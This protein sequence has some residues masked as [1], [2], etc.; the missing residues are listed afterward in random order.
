MEN[1]SQSEG[2]QKLGLELSATNITEGSWA[3]AVW[4]KGTPQRRIAFSARTRLDHGKL[5]PY[6]AF[7]SVC[8]T[9]AGM[10]ME[11]GEDAYQ[12]WLRC[13]EFPDTNSYRERFQ[14]LLKQRDAL[15]STLGHAAVYDVAALRPE[16]QR[17]RAL[18]TPS[19]GIRSTNLRPA[20][21]M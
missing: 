14:Q 4:Q 20:P 6:D 18:P 21:G 2:W 9:I 1:L 16:G 3:I 19:T 8:E 10:P 12:I 11:E 15:F 7:V 17:K 5:D 13:F